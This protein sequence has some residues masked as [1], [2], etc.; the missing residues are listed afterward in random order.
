MQTRNRVLSLEVVW[1]LSKYIRSLEVFRKILPYRNPFEKRASPNQPL[2]LMLRRDP[3]LAVLGR[4]HRAPA[5]VHRGHPEPEGAVHRTRDRPERAA[6]LRRRCRRVRGASAPGPRRPARGRPRPPALVVRL[7]DRHDADDAGP[8][9]GDARR[10]G[11]ISRRT[12]RRCRDGRERVADGGLVAMA[13]TRAAPS[14]SSADADMW[15]S[16]RG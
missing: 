8:G 12:E 13:T 1:F 10:R 3:M 2:H 16:R 11:G 15:V 14:F 7:H 6:A 4:R 9:S 5:S